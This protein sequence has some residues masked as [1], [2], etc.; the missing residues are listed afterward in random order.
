[1]RYP[2]GA[3]IRYKYASKQPAPDSHPARKNKYHANKTIV[4]GIEFASKAEAAYYVQVRNMDGWT[5]QEHFAIIK[6]FKAGGKVYSGARY[7][8]NFVHRADGKIDKVV[9][10]KGGNVTLTTDAKLRM[11]LFMQ[12]YGVPI[13]IARYDYHSGTF[14]EEQL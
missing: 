2:T 6:S 14:E 11:K 1:M 5:M 10:V 3:P 7:T 12:T 8:P 4:D 13:T 9:D